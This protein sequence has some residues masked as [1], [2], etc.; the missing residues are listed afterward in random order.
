MCHVR[1]ENRRSGDD[2]ALLPAVEPLSNS[3]LELFVDVSDELGCRAIFYCGPDCKRKDWMSHKKSCKEFSVNRYLS[4]LE[5]AKRGDAAA[6]FDVGVCYKFGHGTKK[7]TAKAHYWIH[8]AGNAGD[9]YAQYNMGVLYYRA[10]LSR[11]IMS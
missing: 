7:D 4:S 10:T 9:M 5:A 8:R 11:R 2:L 6:Q 1:V 3:R